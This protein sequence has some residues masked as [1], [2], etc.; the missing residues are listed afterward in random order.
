MPRHDSPP[1]DPVVVRR[2]D[3]CKDTDPVVWSTGSESRSTHLADPED[4][5]LFLEGDNIFLRRLSIVNEKPVRVPVVLAFY[6]RAGL[7]VST[8]TICT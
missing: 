2:K 1:G 5:R 8:T 7:L 4:L 6:I 3:T